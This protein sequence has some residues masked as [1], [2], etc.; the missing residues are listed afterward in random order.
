MTAI[1]LGTDIFTGEVV[2]Q[3]LSRFTHMLVAG[4]TGFGKSVF[5]LQLI[6]QMVRHPDID[7]VHLVDLKE[8]VEFNAFEHHPNVTI[9][10]ELE[11]LAILIG[12]LADTVRERQQHLRKQR[13][14]RWSG[15]RTVLVIDEYSEIQWRAADKATRMQL[16]D[17]LNRLAAGSRSAGLI[18]IAATQKPTVDA[19]DSAFSAN[20][21]TR[22]CFKV[23]SNLVAAMVLGTLD[24]L[25]RE[26]GL[27]PATLRRGWCV[28]RDGLTG[29]ARYLQPHVAPEAEETRA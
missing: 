7:A 1:T 2:Q 12:R 9:A 18:L 25:R 22:V 14:R 6:S 16:L 24:D 17:T 5:L 27:D 11:D 10:W 4:S 13:Q 28:M 29:E 19:M 23:A 8:G 20:L 15:P 26:P 3:P 21:P